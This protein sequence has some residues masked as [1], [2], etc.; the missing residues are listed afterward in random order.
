MYGTGAGPAGHQSGGGG[1]KPY[2]KDDLPGGIPV[3]EGLGDI[4]T[5]KTVWGYPESGESQWSTPGKSAGT[6][7]WRFFVSGQWAALLSGTFPGLSGGGAQNG[8]LYW[9]Q[10]ENL[11][12]LSEIYFAGWLP[13]I[14]H[15]WNISGCDQLS[16]HI[17]AVRQ[18]AGAEDCAGYLSDHWHYSHGRHRHESV[19]VQGG[20]GYCGQAYTAGWKWRKDCGAGRID[21]PEAVVDPQAPDGF[22]AGWQRVCEKTGRS[23]HV[24]HGW[25]G[26]VFHWTAGGLL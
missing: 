19:S 18:G 2:P 15:W 25:C 8:L 3:T 10:Y 22:L 21:L 11:W 16:G 20:Y 17:P 12:Y 26:G 9:I 4:R 23:W 7:V 6:P 24:Y 13:C 14:F 5:C 1:W